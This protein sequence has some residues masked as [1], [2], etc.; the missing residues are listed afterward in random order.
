[1]IRAGIASQK[2]PRQRKP[3]PKTVSNKSKNNHTNAKPQNPS[4]T[5][6]LN[7]DSLALELDSSQLEALKSV[8]VVVEHKSIGEFNADEVKALAKKERLNA[9]AYDYLGTYHTKRGISCLI[10]K[11]KRAKSFKLTFKGLAQYSQTS[12]LMRTDLIEVLKLIDKAGKDVKLARLDIA[13][14]TPRLASKDNAQIAKNTKREAFK[15]KNTTYFKTPAEKARHK[16]TNERLDI[17]TYAKPYAGISRL[18]FCFKGSFFSSKSTALKRVQKTI[19]KASKNTSFSKADLSS[20]SFDIFAPNKLI[21]YFSAYT[22]PKRRPVRACEQFLSLAKTSPKSKLLKPV[23]KAKSA[24][25]IKPSKKGF[26][27]LRFS[28]K[29]NLQKAKITPKPKQTIN[30]PP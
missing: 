13:L 23:F 12:E 5:P 25:K 20:L 8:G 14:D 17:K 11:H 27:K 10:T 6:V 18:E 3:T 26:K 24:K 22:Q 4:Q 9:K 1:M 21:D 28:N 2:A 16:R 19:V 30:A 15:F 29:F 7:I